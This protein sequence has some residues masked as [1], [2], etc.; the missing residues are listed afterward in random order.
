MLMSPFRVQRRDSSRLQR[1]ELQCEQ[2]VWAL[3]R[4]FTV[5]EN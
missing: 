1:V 3:N 5:G 2:R 4:D